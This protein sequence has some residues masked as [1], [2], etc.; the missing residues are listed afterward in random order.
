[1]AT[2]VTLTP[3]LPSPQ[4]PGSAV[5]FTAQGIGSYG[6]QYRFYLDSG[7]GFVEVQT[8]GSSNAWTM[9]NTTPVGNY[10]VW[11]EVRTTANSLR[12]ANAQVLYLI[13][14][15]P[16][17]GLALASNFASPHSIA[18][19]Q[20][21]VFTA[22]GQGSPGSVFSYRFY[23]DSG[24]GFVEVQTW[25][26]SN[27]WTMPDTTPVGTYYVWAE[28]RTSTNSPRDATAQVRYLIDV[29]PATGLT[30]TSN[31]ASPHTMTLGQ[32]VV[33]TATGQGS[34]GSVFSYR[35]YLDSGTGFVEVQTWGPSN[36]WTM[37]DT[38]PVGT[39]YVWAEVRTSTSSPRDATWQV[40]YQIVP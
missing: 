10:Y 36:T 26:P 6:Y 4:N 31:F 29:P 33:F 22:T 7:S 28:V 5:T 40:L 13:D 21:V 30:L 11:A 16:A 39:Y 15:P 1:V 20:P 14:V 38:T 27:T 8:W 35:F 32:P 2:G 23:L 9:P 37:S 12:D 19:G 17:T 24:A 34:P 18:L 3:S 25:G